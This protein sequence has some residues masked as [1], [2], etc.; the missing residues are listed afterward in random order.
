VLAALDLAR[1][2]RVVVAG[3]DPPRPKPSPEPLEYVAARLGVPARA[4]VMVGDGPQDVLAGRAA[5]AY[6][7][8]VRGGMA[9]DERLLAAEPHAVLASLA[10]LPALVARLATGSAG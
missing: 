7:V 6:T 8:A 3:G 9:S 5:G 10:E 1:Y 4:L 2:F